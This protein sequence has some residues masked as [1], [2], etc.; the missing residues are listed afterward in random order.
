MPNQDGWLRAALKC[1]VPAPLR[2]LPWRWRWV[3]AT[4]AYATDRKSVV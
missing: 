3:R 1:L 2:S 4:Q